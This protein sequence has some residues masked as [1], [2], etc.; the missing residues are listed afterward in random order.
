MAFSVTKNATQI[1]FLMETASVEV[2]AVSSFEFET[3]SSANG[4]FNGIVEHLRGECGGNPHLKGVISI[5]ASSNGRNQCPQV[6][7]Y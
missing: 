6:V 7:D 3:F 1:S 5:T 2:P 4:A